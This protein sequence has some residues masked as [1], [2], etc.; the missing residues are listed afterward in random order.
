MITLK[1][2]KLLRKRFEKIAAKN[3]YMMGRFGERY[4]NQQTE[5]AWR[6]FVM[7]EVEKLL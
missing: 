6:G 1:H 2:E 4:I 7:H 5:N 3:G